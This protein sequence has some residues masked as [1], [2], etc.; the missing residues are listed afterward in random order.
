[1][2][3]QENEDRAMRRRR[4]ITEKNNG[5]RTEIEVHTIPQE[6]SNKVKQGGKYKIKKTGGNTQKRMEILNRA[7][8]ANENINMPTM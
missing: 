4:Y 5:K 6:T 1:M 7:R 2:E 3:E 8:K